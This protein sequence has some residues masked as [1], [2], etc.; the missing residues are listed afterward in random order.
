MN[1]IWEAAN[2]HG[3]PRLRDAL[4]ID[5]VTLV[6]QGT[7][8]S[9]RY[10]TDNARDGTITRDSAI[11]CKSASSALQM[12]LTSSSKSAGTAPQVVSTIAATSGDLVSFAVG[13]LLCAECAR[14]RIQACGIGKSSGRAVA[15]ATNQL[16]VTTCDRVRFGVTRNSGFAQKMKDLSVAVH[17]LKRKKAVTS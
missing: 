1:T 8:H 14:I 10:E 5:R 9:G 13:Y 12:Q 3:G 11:P 17:L 6:Q 4:Q 15:E 2:A 16:E 7:R